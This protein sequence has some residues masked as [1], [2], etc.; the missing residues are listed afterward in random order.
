[1]NS[2]HA[3]RS[4]KLEQGERLRSSKRAGLSHV[5][6]GGS[7]RRPPEVS[8]STKIKSSGVGGRSSEKSG[9]ARKCCNLR[10]ILISSIVAI[11]TVYCY[12]R[13]YTTV[14]DFE[15]KSS[16]LRGNDYAITK[17]KSESEGV[18]Q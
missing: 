5:K 14:L 12:L 8:F 6:G 13:M 1:M 3:R 17:A 10:R 9:S 2:L 18:G 4:P 15:S 16:F 11:F 7:L